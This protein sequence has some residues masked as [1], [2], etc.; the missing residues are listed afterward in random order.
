MANLPDRA[1]SS[2]NSPHPWRRGGDAPPKSQLSGKDGRRAGPELL[3]FPQTEEVFAEDKFSQ[4]AF[5]L[6]HKAA[7]A[8]QLALATCLFGFA[9]AA[10]S[11]FSA[12]QWS[13]FPGS[14]PAASDSA[15]QQQKKERAELA[16]AV[17]KLSGDVRALETGMA[18]LRAGQNQ[19][20][21]SRT[22]I[23]ALTARLDAEKSETRAAIASA[24]AEAER[25]RREQEAA[26][27]QL[28]G[29]LDRL[30]RKLAEKEAA[31]GAPPAASEA[32]QKTAAAG[33]DAARPPPDNAEGP[34]K[35][36]LITNW[37]VRDVYRGVALLESTHGTIEVAPGEMVPGAGRVKSIE[38]RPT[39][40]IVITSRGVVDSASDVFEP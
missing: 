27:P 36:H 19:A 24:S 13:L 12:H 34:K 17:K 7:L 32:S 16:R 40:W 37:V 15:F 2:T 6:E 26:L 1:F 33:G 11:Y 18:A 30:E 38:R 14:E 22:G 39:G 31:S 9:W 10:S 25:L 29:R 28:A 35:P 8:P 20:A 23:E 3:P 5:R 4:R 21:N